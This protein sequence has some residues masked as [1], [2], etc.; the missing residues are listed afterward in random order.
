MKA[1]LVAGID[2]AG[3]GPL[4]G[5]MVVAAVAIRVD[6]LEELV[7]LGVS[8]SKLLSP[9]ERE[10]LYSSI[11]ARAEHTIVVELPPEAIDTVNLNTLEHDTYAL[12]VSRLYAMHRSRLA[13]IVV[14][15]VG[16]PHQLEKLLRRIAPSVEIIATPRA[17]LSYT[18][19]AAASV[20][21]KVVRDRRVR[22]LARLYGDFGSG[23]PTDP[24]TLE[25]IRRTY[26]RSPNNPPPIV[27]RSWA[28][29]KKIA[30]GWYRPKSANSSKNLLDYLK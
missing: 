20:V 28:T 6:R 29:L 5:P 26:Q 8:D 22:E 10:K 11:V 17:E 18:E 21:A 12:L 13:R 2:E 27:R 3:R 7:R 30:P 24:K 25:W 9:V 16:P 19:V 15:T 4:I 14:D 23:Y 1:T